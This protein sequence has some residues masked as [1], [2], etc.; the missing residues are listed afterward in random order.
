MRSEVVRL[1]SLGCG[2]GR[3]TVLG[4]IGCGRCTLWCPVGIDLTEER[5]ALAEEA[6]L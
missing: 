3:C 6:S 5:P 1:T 2:C 4:C